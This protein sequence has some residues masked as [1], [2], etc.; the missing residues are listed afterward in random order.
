MHFS[1]CILLIYS[2]LCNRKRQK[3]NQTGVLRQFE[4]DTHH[5]NQKTENASFANGG[6]H[7]SAKA[8]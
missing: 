2:Y 8:D 4:W 6:P 7:K 3:L 5:K 1:F